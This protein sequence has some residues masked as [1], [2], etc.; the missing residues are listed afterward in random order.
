MYKAKPF[1]CTLSHTHSLFLSLTHAHA[2]IYISNKWGFTKWPKEEYKEM[3]AD[4]RLVPDGVHV[5]Y[6][7]AKGPLSA[8]KKRQTA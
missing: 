6:K 3:M 7:P 1:T 4:G 2:Q 5:Q 8:W